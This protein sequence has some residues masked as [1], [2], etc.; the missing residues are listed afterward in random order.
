MHCII[1]YAKI[2]FVCALFC[3]IESYLK[4]Y[5]R[6]VSCW[7]ISTNFNL[8]YITCVSLSGFEFSAGLGLLTALTTIL[9]R[10]PPGD[11]DLALFRLVSVLSDDLLLAPAWFNALESNCFLII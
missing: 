6:L 8:S 11:S 3:K 2:N 1:V 10:V 5:T 7:C 4:S 9:L